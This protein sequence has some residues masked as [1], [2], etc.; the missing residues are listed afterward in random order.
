MSLSE[1]MSTGGE[2]PPKQRRRR[3]WLTCLPLVVLL[4]VAA[5]VVTLLVSKGRNLLPG[6]IAEG[7]QVQTSDGIVQ[8]SVDQMRNASTIAAVATA[9]N[10]PER[11]VTIS[12]ATAMQESRLTNLTGGDRDSIGLFQQRPSQGWGTPTQIADPVYA[13]NKFLDKLVEIPG[14]AQLPLTQAAQ[15]VQHSGF[16][17]AYAQHEA[18]AITLASAL[19]GRV[20]AAMTCSVNSVGKA[21]AG[22]GTTDLA[23]AL[24][25]DFGRVLSTSAL[26]ADPATGSGS[27]NA[28]TA[29]TQQQLAVSLRSGS[30][31]TQHGWAVAQWSVAHAQ[32]LHITAVEYAGKRWTSA[33]SDKGWVGTASASAGTASADA[34]TSGLR[35]TVASA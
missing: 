11:A 12:L 8:L 9:R 5:V 4:V 1:M 3:R 24:K 27:G 34:S 18:D 13:T 30:Y 22:T 23:A 10:L 28:A 7:C 19:S 31:Q 15:D 33:D 21:A 32:V 29:P 25:K 6:P 35:L 26:G 14:Y 16:P 20:H 17:D 2:V